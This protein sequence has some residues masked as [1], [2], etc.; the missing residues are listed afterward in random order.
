MSSFDYIFP[1]IFDPDPGDNT[2]I[3]SVRNSSGFL[4]DFIKFSLN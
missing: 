3:L 2:T 1:T 4:P